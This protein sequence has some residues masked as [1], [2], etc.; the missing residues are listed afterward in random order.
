MPFR[1]GPYAMSHVTQEVVYGRILQVHTADGQTGLGE[2]VFPPSLSVDERQRLIADEPFYLSSLVGKEVDGLIQLAEELCGSGRSWS[3]IVF[4]L[5][6][7]GYDLLEQRHT[8]W[9]ADEVRR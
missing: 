1:D 4:G 5:Q 7:A 6:T 2:V 9:L 8:E 3:G